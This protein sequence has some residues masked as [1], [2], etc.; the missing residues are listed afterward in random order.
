MFLSII[1]ALFILLMGAVGWFFFTHDPARYQQIGWLY[2]YVWLALGA[3]LILAVIIICIDILAPRKKLLIFSGT[4][5]GLIVGL[6]IA[7]ALSFVVSLLLDQTRPEAGGLLDN[8]T[9]D[10]L[11]TSIDLIVGVICC[12]LA[13]SFILQT[14]DDFRFVIPYV[15]FRRQAKGPKPFI[16]DTSVLIDGRI[17]DIAST[18]I[19]ESTLVVPRFVMDELQLVADSEDKLK[20]SRGRRG[21]DVLER[22]RGN[23]HVELNL[24]ESST[25][26][27]D[28]TPVDQQLMDLAKQMEGRLLTNDFNLHKVANLRGITVINLNDLATSLRSA[29]LPGEVLRLHLIKPGEEQGQAIGYLEDGTM[30]VVEQGRPLIN[31]EADV[32]VTNSRQ[33][34]A[35]RMIFARLADGGGRN[36]PAPAPSGGARGP[37]V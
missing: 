34:A 36:T 17:D 33:T 11:R 19:F 13:I 22:L 14:K 23:E 2:H 35:G 27:D 21:L 6:F 28:R 4:V 9:V 37:R 25:R 7:Y 1:R 16:L 15:E 20:R 24:Y 3:S 32:L 10:A 29:A 12:Y 8:K 26:Q 18:G 30:V 5:L 31:S